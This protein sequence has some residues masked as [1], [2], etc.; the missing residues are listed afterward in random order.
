MY[1]VVCPLFPGLL[2]TRQ[3]DHS[4]SDWTR[5]CLMWWWAV[6]ESR[7]ALFLFLPCSHCAPVTFNTKQSHTLFRGCLKLFVVWISEGRMSTEC[8]RLHLKSDWRQSPDA[9]CGKDQIDG[10]WREKKENY[11]ELHKDV[12][13]VDEYKYRGVTLTTNK[14]GGP[15]TAVYKKSCSRLYFLQK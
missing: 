3:I 7:R 13:L 2:S 8:C 5:S 10:D 4:K 15:H 6:R 12:D 9:Y 1:I 14:T 11:T